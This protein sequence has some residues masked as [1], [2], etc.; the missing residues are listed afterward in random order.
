MIR[1]AWF[2]LGL[3]AL[4]ACTDLLGTRV[5]RVPLLIVPAFNGADILAANADLLHILVTRVD[6][7]ALGGAIDTA[8]NTTVPI[9]A[10]SGT[11]KA[12]LT[13]VVLTEP[14]V[15]V[16]TLEAIRSS[17]GVVLFSGTQT[18]SVSRNSGSGSGQQVQI[19][20]SYQGPRGATVAVTPRDTSVALAG[21]FK[22]KAVVRDSGGAVV[23]VPVTFQLRRKADST[24]LTVNRYTGAAVAASTGQGTVQ[25]IALSAD[26]LADTATIDVGVATPVAITITPG[27]ADVGAGI[28]ATFSAAVTDAN[29]L[30][31]TS[32]VSWTSRA[33][34]VASVGASSGQVTGVAAGTAVIVAKSGTLSDSALVTVPLAGN[35]VVSTTS[36]GR[37]FR[38][39]KVG[40]TVVVAVTADMAF[41]PSE[42]LGSYNATLTWDPT[43]LKYVD[44][45]AGAFAAPTVNETAA[46]TGTVRFSSADPNGSGGAVVLA[47]VRFVAQAQGA[48]A[49][50]LTISEMSA[51]KTYTNLLSRVTVTN[52]KITVRP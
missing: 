48:G 20:V 42:V 34:A 28:S 47:K 9:N 30:P 26:S 35:V 11:A 14:T 15:F 18:V 4:T 25:V 36:N 2:A 13:V 23:A 45:Q 19:P 17:D 22:F 41:T 6:T 49:M 8:A 51:A 12:N 44:L 40:D 16:V 31:V 37:A 32:A 38:A 43:K 1:R 46:A 39:P 33:P 7:G 21:A 27:Y 3:V 10:D 5:H 52:G 24:L 29:G 50:A